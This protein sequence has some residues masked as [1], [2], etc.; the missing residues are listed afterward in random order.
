MPLIDK[1]NEL[2][3]QNLNL[4]N[5]SD[6]NEIKSAISSFMHQISERMNMTEKDIWVIDRLEGNYAICENRETKEKREV[7]IEK[8]PKEIKEGS[9]L[10]YK[11]GEYTLNLE[12]ENDIQKRIE[13]KM[14]D[15]WN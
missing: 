2:K 3:N 5:N 13:Q 8:L 11:N 10:N 12:K 6:F 9:V 15:I 7:E 1:N 14:K 4:E